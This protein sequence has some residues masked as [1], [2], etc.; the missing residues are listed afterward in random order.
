MDT[1]LSVGIIARN[2][3]LEVAVVKLGKVTAAITFPDTH[4]GLEALKGFLASHRCSIRLAVA[5][6]ASLGVALA[7]GNFSGREAFILSLAVAD[8]A[9]ALARYAEHAY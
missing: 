9:V 1:D 4:M 8:Q 5:G 7:V 3:M 2:N 6:A